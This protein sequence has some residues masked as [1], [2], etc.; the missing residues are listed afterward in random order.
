MAFN[1]ASQ[2]FLKISI[3]APIKRCLTYRSDHPSNINSSVWPDNVLT[4]L[5]YFSAETQTLEKRCYYVCGI[6]HVF[7][8][9]VKTLGLPTTIYITNTY[10]TFQR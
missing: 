8:I 5:S 6:K 4:V 7:S 9:T 3:D 10:A 1:S 2:R